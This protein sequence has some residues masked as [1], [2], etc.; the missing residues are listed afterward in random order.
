[1]AV[2]RWETMKLCA[3]EL[4]FQQALQPRNQ[5]NPLQT[6]Y[7]LI[8]PNGVCIVH[9]SH[10]SRAHSHTPYFSSIFNVRRGISLSLI[11]L[12]ENVMT[13]LNAF[14]CRQPASQPFSPRAI[15]NYKWSA[16]G[17]LS[18]HSRN[19]I[20]SAPWTGDSG[21]PSQTDLADS[22][23]ASSEAEIFCRG[24]Q[25]TFWPINQ[26]PV[27]PFLAQRQPNAVRAM[28]YGL[29]NSDYSRT[30]ARRLSHS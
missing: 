21:L 12:P 17:A 27:N 7:I 2:G 25:L 6:A 24:C 3:Q 10:I 4:N 16:S 18:T 11:N 14:V 20:F 28:R 9:R 19:S 5:Q 15:H 22:M 26:R 29:Q 8:S 13:L 1:M 23:A 30:Q